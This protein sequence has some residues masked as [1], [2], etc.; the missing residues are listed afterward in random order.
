MTEHLVPN[1]EAGLRFLA[2]LAT[3][4]R[5]P[6]VADALD[7]FCGPTHDGFVVGMVTLLNTAGAMLSSADGIRGLWGFELAPMA[8][9]PLGPAPIAAA[10]SWAARFVTAAM[11]GDHAAAFALWYAVSSEEEQAAQAKELASMA[12]PLLAHSVKAFLAAGRQL[13]LESFSPWEVGS[14]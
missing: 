10:T 13:D 6:E 8:M 3:D 12:I 9:T 5:G 14:S 7:E 2:M 4:T 1:A 11:N